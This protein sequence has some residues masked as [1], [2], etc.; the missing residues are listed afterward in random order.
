M[1]SFLYE[2]YLFIKRGYIQRKSI[3]SKINKDEPSKCVGDELE[4]DFDTSSES[5]T[6]AK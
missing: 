5:R 6:V 3:L 1:L 4:D 2:R